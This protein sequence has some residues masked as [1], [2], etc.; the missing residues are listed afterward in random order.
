MFKNLSFQLCLVYGRCSVL[1]EPEMSGKIN[2]PAFIVNLPSYIPSHTQHPTLSSCKKAWTD[3]EFSSSEKRSQLNPNE[4]F[5]WNSPE[6]DR[7]SGNKIWLASLTSFQVCVWWVVEWILTMPL[8]LVSVLHRTGFYGACPPSVPAKW[9]TSCSR[10]L[11][12]PSPAPA[13][14]AP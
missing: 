6:D 5:E 13:Q 2:M 11:Q 4:P 14:A 8:A 3:L 9:K 12:T 1:A 10:L 7:H